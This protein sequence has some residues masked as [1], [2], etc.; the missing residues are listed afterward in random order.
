MRNPDFVSAAAADKPA[1]PQSFDITR[2]GAAFRR[3]LRTGVL[4][5]LQDVAAR[6][7]DAAAGRLGAAPDS[8]AV[9]GSPEARRVDESFRP[10]FEARGR[11]RLDPEGRSAKN[12]HLTE[13]TQT[14][15]VAQ[16]LVDPEGVND[17]EARFTVSLEASRGASR[18]VL[19]FVEVAPVGGE[20]PVEV[21]AEPL[22]PEP[23]K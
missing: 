10:F 9:E 3:L 5:F 23:L 4:V 1:R 6:D 14:W 20:A 12:L 8:P 22:V 2:D 7:W 11:F 15:E 13:E 17:W 19:E 18:V 16:I 21:T